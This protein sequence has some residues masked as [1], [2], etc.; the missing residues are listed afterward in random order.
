MM[1]R[2][3]AKTQEESETRMRGKG[4]PNVTP[5]GVFDPVTGY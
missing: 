5:F 3:K 2:R 1:M 4:I